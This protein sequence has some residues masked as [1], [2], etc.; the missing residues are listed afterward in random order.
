MATKKV[1]GSKVEMTEVLNCHSVPTKLY[2]DIQRHMFT[3]L[4]HV[5]PNKLYTLKKMCGKEFWKGMN[6]WQKR[7]AGRAFAH[8][9]HVGIFPFDFIKHKS[10]TK[11]YLLK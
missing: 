8:M 6:S 1:S 2:E 10:P 9:V 4:N 7:K 3:Q 11:R 5:L